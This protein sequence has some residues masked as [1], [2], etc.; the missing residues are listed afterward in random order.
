MPDGD[1]SGFSGSCVFPAWQKLWGDNSALSVRF[2]CSRCFQFSWWLALNLAISKFRLYSETDLV[3]YVDLK[4]PFWDS[5]K[6]VFVYFLIKSFHGCYATTYKS[7]PAEL[8]PDY[9]CSGR[10]SRIMLSNAGSKMLLVLDPAT[11]ANIDSIRPPESF[12][13]PI[14]SVLIC[15]FYLLLFIT[16]SYRNHYFPVAKAPSHTSTMK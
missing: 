7:R 14:V 6:E 3:K 11:Q 8:F 2:S 9:R 16:I 5:K 13:L 15:F 4:N 10:S 1:I 12:P